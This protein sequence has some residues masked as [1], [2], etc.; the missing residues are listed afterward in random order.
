MVITW[1]QCLKC[2]MFTQ[3]IPK[4]PERRPNSFARSQFME[5][6]AREWLLATAA[7]QV[8]V[9]RCVAYMWR[10]GAIARDENG[11]M[12]HLS[13]LETLFRPPTSP[14]FLSEEGRNLMAG[15]ASR[16]VGVAAIG[17]M[18]SRSALTISREV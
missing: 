4:G 18:V 2:I 3:R 13:R 1:N 12:K 9:G 14:R 11:S 7:R 16:G 15:F 5:L 8:S 10:E 17:V 6:I